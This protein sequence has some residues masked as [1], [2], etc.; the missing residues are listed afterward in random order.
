MKEKC[1]KILKKYEKEMLISKPL[2]LF[3]ET[4]DGSNKETLNL[5]L[6]S[7][8]PFLNEYTKNKIKAEGYDKLR[9][10]ELRYQAKIG[11]LRNEYKEFVES[12]GTNIPIPA[13]EKPKN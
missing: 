13:P 6:V 8:I 2:Q 5:F 4:Y 12:K 9:E 10:I 11:L 1:L 3:I 7:L